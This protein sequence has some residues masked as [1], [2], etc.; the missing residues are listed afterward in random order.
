M[1]KKFKNGLFGKISLNKIINVCLRNISSCVERILL[2]SN[3]IFVHGLLSSNIVFVEWE[4]KEEDEEKEKKKNEKIKK[5]YEE[6]EKK[7]KKEK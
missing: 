2:S 5:E 4:E 1:K 3:K 6:K 7:E